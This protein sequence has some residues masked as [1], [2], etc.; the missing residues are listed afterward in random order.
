MTRTIIEEPGVIFKLFV[1]GYRELEPTI[2]I[3]PTMHALLD[4]AIDGIVE[5]KELVFLKSNSSFEVQP[6]NSMKIVGAKRCSDRLAGFFE[7]MVEQ[8]Q[9]Q[10]CFRVSAA[11]AVEL[12]YNFDCDDSEFSQDLL[13]LERRDGGYNLSSTKEFAVTTGAKLRMWLEPRDAYDWT[14]L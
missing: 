5:G 11:R 12:L 4:K 1:Q 10:K 8:M 13:R 14:L 7:A 9:E 2:A 6:F 3:Q